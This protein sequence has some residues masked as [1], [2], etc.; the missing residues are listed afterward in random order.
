[1]KVTK[2]KFGMLCD[3]TKVNLY[4]VKNGNMS[5]SC[6]DYGCTITSIVLNDGENKKTDV[7]LGYSTLE[8]YINGNVF[9][10]AI[11]G[12]F[13]NR[14]GKAAFELD[15]KKYEL[16]KDSGLIILDRILY[17]STHYPANYGFIPKTL[18]SDHD[19]LDV[20][21]LCSE[22]LDPLTLVRCYPIGLIPM[23]DSGLE[24]EKIIAIPFADPSYNNITNIADLQPHVIREIRHF[25]RVYGELQNKVTNVE[26]A[27]GP[28]AAKKVI[29]EAIERYRENFPE[30]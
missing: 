9:F 30:A 1:M 8:G 20:L 3:G 7:L 19:P 16:D 29:A 13:A 28:N 12:R 24:D 4:T 10:G 25:F 6:T 15:G 22:P 2:S 18:G 21:V 5:F 26:K 14:I 23:V 11:V 17:T 27:T